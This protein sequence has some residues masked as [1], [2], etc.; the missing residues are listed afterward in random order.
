MIAKSKLIE[1]LDKIRE[2]L[3]KFNRCPKCGGRKKEMIYEEI[4]V[5]KYECKDCG[6]E[7]SYF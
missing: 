7:L 4:S 5:D 1:W 2:V 6:C 3:I